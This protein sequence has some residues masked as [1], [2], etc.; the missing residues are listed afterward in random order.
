LYEYHAII[1]DDVE[2]AFFTHEQLALLDRF[3]AERG[4]GLLMLGGLETFR[5]GDW[6]RTPLKDAL[7]VYLDR[8]STEPPR[9][10]KMR[11]TRD[12][13]LQPWV[14]LR[15]TED[16]EQTRLQKMPA[17]HVLSTVKTVKPAA[18]VM[19]E[20]EDGEGQRYPAIVAQQY[21]K[22][23]TGAVLLGDTWRWS[24]QRDADDQDDLAKSW[25]QAIRW[26]VSDVPLRI[27][28]RVTW[29]TAGQSKALL[30]R[31]SVRDKSFE[32]QDNAAVHVTIHSP[33]GD[34]LTMDAQPSLSEPGVFE[35]TYVP[36][37]AGAYRAEIQVDDAQGQLAGV[38]ETGWT[39]DP[40]ADEFQVIGINRT[41][42]EEIST[43]SG[44][45][46]LRESQ[47]ADFVASLPYRNV[48]EQE[49]QTF[50]LW[51]SPWL[52]LAALTC[53]A[54]EWGLRRI[55]GLP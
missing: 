36:R 20:V 13:W 30:L 45:E 39:S 2:A 32:P 43:R 19:A 35:A 23:H 53:L 47:L 14:R 18:Q 50:P 11:L 31:I 5:Q 46:V 28:P 38:A 21:G 29:T 10:L 12:G 17:F 4:G 3:V 8:I 26:L 16:K 22:G 37:E 42:A 9:N 52:L 51:H 48:P 27:D 40:A 6:G 24:I 7:P 1:L 34:P 33:T 15:D 54:L 44:G 49:T 55:S 41:L 25:R